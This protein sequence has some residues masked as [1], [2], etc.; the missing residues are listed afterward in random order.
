M[1]MNDPGPPAAPSPIDIASV[2]VELHAALRR[3]RA[4]LEHAEIMMLLVQHGYVES[5]N[6]REACTEVHETKSRERGSEV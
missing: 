6:G 2:R 3:A 1:L 4:V 5:T